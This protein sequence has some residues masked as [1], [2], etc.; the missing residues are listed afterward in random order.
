MT[1]RHEGRTAVISGAAS[2]IGQASAIRLAKEGAEIII[3][4][5]DKAKKTL[6]LI[7]DFGGKATAF[8]CDVTSSGQRRSFQGGR[9]CGRRSL[10]HP[11]QQC[12]NLSDADLQ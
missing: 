12:G 1:R 7:A 10:R 9:G 2:G 11:R 5:R 6:Q 3:A 4:D 8:E